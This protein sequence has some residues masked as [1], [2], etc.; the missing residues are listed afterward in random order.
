MW[1][2]RLFLLT[3]GKPPACFG[4]GRSSRGKA[5]RL[6]YCRQAVPACFGHARSSRGTASQRSCRGEFQMADLSTEYSL[7]RR[8]V[9]R[10]SA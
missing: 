8:E 4:H 9:I 3:S 6:T 7:V 5:G 10:V 1:V 2:R